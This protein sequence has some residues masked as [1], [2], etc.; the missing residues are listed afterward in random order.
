MTI[1]VAGANLYKQWDDTLCYSVQFNDDI[2]VVYTL[3][4]N[5]LQ[6]VSMLSV[7]LSSSYITT[8]KW[9]T[10][11][12]MRK[13]HELSCNWFDKNKKRYKLLKN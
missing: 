13:R 2:I 9:P 10:K 7:G 4:K 5:G 12:S 11:H 6:Y 8:R 3:T 1:D